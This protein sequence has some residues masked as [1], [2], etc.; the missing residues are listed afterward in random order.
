M[1]IAL[2]NTSDTLGGAA[3]VT[4]R[5]MEALRNAGHDAR[6]VT[7]VKHGDSPHVMESAT[8]SQRGNRFVPERGWIFLHNGL[9]RENLFKVSIANTGMPLHRHPWIKEADIISLNWINQGTLSIKGIERICALG[10]PVVWTM[11]DMWCMTGACHHAYECTGYRDR[12]GNCQFF[13]GGSSGHD[14]SRSTWLRKKALFDKTD[15]HFVAVSRWLAE[16]CRQSSLLA[17]KPISVIPCAYPV[18]SYHTEPYVT[19]RSYDIDYSRDII[20]MGAARL[21]DPVKGLPYAIKAF[22]YVFDTNPSWANRCLVVFFGNIRNP[23]LLNEMQLPFVHIGQVND[24]KILRELYARAKVVVSSSLY[25]TLGATLIEGQAAGAVPVSFGE[26]GQ[27]DIIEHGV[28]G[29]IAEYRNPESLGRY[30]IKALEQPFDRAFLHN[31]V[32]RRFG[33]ETIAARY[34]DLFQSLLDR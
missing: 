19:M 7:F 17:G 9:N 5:L 25:E 32:T 2:I 30:I 28:N 34:T 20:V 21:D 27:T 13:H 14:L 22:N 1:K 29:Y 15:I 6:M 8:R 31:E 23:R 10:K 16:K 24:P 33:A 11:H 4:Y 12:C 3:I 26:G 18:E